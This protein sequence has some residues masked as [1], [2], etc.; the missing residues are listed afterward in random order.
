MLRRCLK[1]I[2]KSWLDA[3]VPVWKTVV[4]EAWK[5]RLLFPI[6]GLD[7]YGFQMAVTK[8]CVGPRGGTPRNSPIWHVPAI[9]PIS[10]N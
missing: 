2:F 7:D 3:W 10:V 8:L 6:G 1:I 4:V 5:T 9:R